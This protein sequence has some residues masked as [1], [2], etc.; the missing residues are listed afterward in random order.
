MNREV[1]IEKKPAEEE[2]FIEPLSGIYDKDFFFELG[3]N[4]LTITQRYNR[5]TSILYI[6]IE[7]FSEITKSYGEAFAENLLKSFCQ[8]LRSLM[9]E[10]DFMARLSSNSIGVHVAETNAF[11]A[12]LL[13]RRI[14]NAFIISAKQD[15]KNSPSFH[16]N[17]THSTAPDEGT[18]ISALI[19][20]AKEKL[21]KKRRSLAV[22]D[23]VRDLSFLETI[24][25]FIDKKF[26]C[27]SQNTSIFSQGSTVQCQFTSAFI[28]QVQKYILKYV[29]LNRERKGL[30]FIGIQKFQ[31]SWIGIQDYHA[32]RNIETIIYIIG[33]KGKHPFSIPYVIPVYLSDEKISSYRFIFFLSDKY[34]YGLTGREEGK[35]QFLGF[36]SSDF[37]FVEYIISKLQLSYFYQK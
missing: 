2:L 27:P 19:D 8:R 16:L 11:G 4:L 1:K 14:E 5:K 17:I 23:G 29:M 6:S 24:N 33:L 36:H 37:Y 30:L 18:D 26:Q 31:D 20:K 28:D 34:A 3:K 35:N 7:N 22:N 21:E 9:R 13:I 15:K 10:S 12:I 32:L 25:F